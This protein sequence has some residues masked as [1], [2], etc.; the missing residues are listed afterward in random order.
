[1]TFTFIWTLQQAWVEERKFQ[2]MKKEK[3]IDLVTN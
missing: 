2:V 3:Y 1:M